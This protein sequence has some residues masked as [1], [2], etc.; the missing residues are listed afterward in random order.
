MMA[1]SMNLPM[2]KLTQSDKQELPFNFSSHDRKT[3]NK[4]A[5]Q[6]AQQTDSQ[7]EDFSRVTCVF[8]NK[9]KAGPVIE[10]GSNLDRLVNK[11]RMLPRKEVHKLKTE[12]R[13]IK[14]FERITMPIQFCCAVQH[15]N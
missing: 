15:R 8:P 12:D 9:R 6:V 2:K 14:V 13:L 5:I 10:A 1:G 7:E 4:R 3:L 11:P